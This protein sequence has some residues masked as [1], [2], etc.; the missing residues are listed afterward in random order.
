MK[1]KTLLE[2]VE[3]LKEL[4]KKFQEDKH[5]DEDFFYLKECIDALTDAIE[6]QAQR[7]AQFV[8]QLK[9]QNSELDALRDYK[10]RAIDIG[11]QT[12][13]Q[14]EEKLFT[15]IFSNMPA[16]WHEE[17][18]EEIIEI[19]SQRQAALENEVDTLKKMLS[20]SKSENLEQEQELALK[21]IK[22]TNQQE[23]IDNL[24]KGIAILREEL[25]E[26]TEKHKRNDFMLED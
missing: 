11:E 14:I 1:D 23:E 3:K 10:S 8:K 2:I 9:E 7:V 5:K 26:H 25:A 18:K 4:S 19:V 20:K 12:V 16:Q 13:K 6:Q 15:V 17:K 24:T 22:I 21:D